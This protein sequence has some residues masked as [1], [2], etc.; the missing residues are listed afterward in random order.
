MDETSRLM[1]CW[2]AWVSRK[3]RRADRELK[4]L[5]CDDANQHL[6]DFILCDVAA[7]HN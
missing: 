5:M 6:G 3:K 7:S 2:P 4:H 1:Y